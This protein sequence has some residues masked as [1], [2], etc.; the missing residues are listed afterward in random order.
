MGR[1]PLSD[2]EKAIQH[3]LLCEHCL[4][5]VAEIILDQSVLKK[6]AKGGRPPNRP[7]NWCGFCQGPCKLPEN[8]EA[9]YISPS[10][11]GY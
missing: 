5:K 3:I 2:H 11:E 4:A 8:P 7:D 6:K 1:H 10:S 9:H